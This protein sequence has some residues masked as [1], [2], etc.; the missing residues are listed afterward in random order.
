[1]RVD[2][3]T[4]ECRV[5]GQAKRAQ[6][7]C[8]CTALTKPRRA[9]MGSLKMLAF[10]GRAKRQERARESLFLKRGSRTIFH[11]TLVAHLCKV[12]YFIDWA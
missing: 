5:F 7:R 4:L 8:E 10:L 9:G 12:H 11:K 3:Y 2:F 6:T 1:M